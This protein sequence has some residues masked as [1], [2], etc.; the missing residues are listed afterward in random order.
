MTSL[1]KL[2]AVTMSRIRSPLRSPTASALGFTPGATVKLRRRT[3]SNVVP[4][5][6]P[7]QT[8]RWQAS[9]DKAGAQRCPSWFDC[10]VGVRT[11]ED[12]DAVGEGPRG[13][14]DVGQ[15][16]AVEEAEGQGHGD[17]AVSQLEEPGFAECS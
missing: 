10:L 11:E 6:R 13:D 2:L 9:N 7:A 8:V 17:R 3:V 5:P 4:S 15:D 16:V 12:E 1:E 14:G